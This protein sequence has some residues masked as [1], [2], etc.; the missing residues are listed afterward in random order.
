MRY[1]FAN[2][3]VFYSGGDTPLTSRFE[4]RIGIDDVI[5]FPAKT[6]NGGLNTIYVVAIPDKSSIY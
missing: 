5:K 2:D 4:T 3:V 6:S 1:S